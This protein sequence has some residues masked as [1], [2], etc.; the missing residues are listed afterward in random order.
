MK[1]ISTF[2]QEFQN[3]QCLGKYPNVLLNRI[4]VV[5]LAL[6]QRRR[7]S[8]RKLEVWRRLFRY[9]NV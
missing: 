8:R 7:Q 4:V 3:V 9:K 2:L 5:H 6:T 1:F